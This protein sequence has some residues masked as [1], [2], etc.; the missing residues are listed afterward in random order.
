M[1]LDTGR[2]DWLIFGFV[3]DAWPPMLVRAERMRHE[4]RYLQT[5]ACSPIWLVAV[6]VRH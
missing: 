5:A 3:V 6:R 4:V 2:V 1:H